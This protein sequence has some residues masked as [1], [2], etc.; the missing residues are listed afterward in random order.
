M[1]TG[2][3]RYG[4]GRPGWRRKCENSLPIDIRRLH[5]KQLLR[6]GTS[7]GWHWSRDDEEIGSIGIDVLETAVQF[8]YAWTPRDC[9][10]VQKLYRA[11]LERTP[12]RYG[13]FRTWYRCPWCDRRCAVLYGLSR[14]GY[15]GCRLCLRLA[16]AS[17]AEDTCDRLWRKKRKLEARLIDD[18]G[19]PKWMR[20]TTYVRILEHIDAV[21]EALDRNFLARAVRMFGGRALPLDYL[22]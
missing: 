13:G 20:A 10:P 1:G 21:E 15:F 19:K 6:P 11:A 4:A 5:Q 18:D 2:G 14:D 16:Y 22:L 9:D 17:E 12:C 7:F 3:S 8:R